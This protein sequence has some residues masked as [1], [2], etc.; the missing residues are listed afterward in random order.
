VCGCPDKTHIG[1]LAVTHVAMNW[2][3]DCCE[4]EKVAD[5]LSTVMGVLTLTFRLGLV[6]LQWRCAAGMS[7]MGCAAARLCAP[8]ALWQA[9]QHGSH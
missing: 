9:S 4:G 8:S 3:A 5:L 6:A 1:L 2:T 7:T